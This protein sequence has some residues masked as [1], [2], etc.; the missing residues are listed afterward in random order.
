M[1]D[2]SHEAHRIQC[3]VEQAAQYIQDTLCAPS[4]IYRPELTQLD[5]EWVAVLRAGQHEVTGRGETPFHAMLAFDRAWSTQRAAPVNK[6]YPL[7][8]AEQKMAPYRVYGEQEAEAFFMSVYTQCMVDAVPVEQLPRATSHV[9]WNCVMLRDIFDVRHVGGHAYAI[10]QAINSLGR[11]N[12]VMRPPT[13]DDRL[14]V[15]P[16]IRA[17]I[18]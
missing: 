6:D 17:H 11:R 13:R 4:V 2:F 7:P 5:G 3:A 14:W 18:R 8:P 15:H 16:Q 12:L 1:T 9:A 10:A